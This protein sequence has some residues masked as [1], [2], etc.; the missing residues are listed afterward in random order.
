MIIYSKSINYRF[1]DQKTT[2]TINNRLFTNLDQMADLN[3]ESKFF[4]VDLQKKLP[5]FVCNRK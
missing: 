3:I 4:L 5:K 2:K 1:L